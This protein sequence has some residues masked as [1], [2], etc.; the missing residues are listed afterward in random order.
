MAGHA[1]L[2]F[3]M[4]ECSKTQIRLTGLN[5]EIY[6]VVCNGFNQ[7]YLAKKNNDHNVGLYI[8][9]R[10][11]KVERPLR[12][13]LIKMIELYCHLHD[14]DLKLLICSDALCRGVRLRK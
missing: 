6:Y 4:T 1:Q 12:T 11:F 13:S 3:V 10:L 5:Y 8:Y 14:R 9:G 2:N 7:T